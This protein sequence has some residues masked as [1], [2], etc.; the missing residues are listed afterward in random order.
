MRKEN[1]V[2]F[3]AVSVALAMAAGAFMVGCSSDSSST[4]TAVDS[5]TPAVDSGTTTDSGTTPATD[6][7]TTPAT[8][9][10]TTADAG[11]D[12]GPVDAGPPGP[13]GIVIDVVHASPDTPAVGLCLG[14]VVGGNPAFPAPFD[15]VQGPLP[16]NAA[17]QIVVPSALQGA[18]GGVE[19]RVYAVP[20]YTI[21]DGGASTCASVTGAGGSAVLLKSFP[22]GTFQAGHGYIV[23][24]TGCSNAGT[25]TV[26]KCG[27]DPT[28]PANPRALG[29]WFKEFDRTF[30]PAGNVGAQFVHL[31]PQAE[32]Q[33]LPV[34]GAGPDGGTAYLPIFA[35]GVK[36]A[37][38][39]ANPADAGT[40]YTWAA[41]ASGADP[42]K[43]FANPTAIVSA[44]IPVDPNTL[45]LGLFT[46]AS[47]AASPSGLTSIASIP[48]QFVAAATVGPT[49]P[50]VPTYFHKGLT[51]TFF[52]VGDLA[53]SSNPQAPNAGPD[54]FRVLALPNNPPPPASD[55]GTP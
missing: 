14:A 19:V 26:A 47:T 42:V 50:A 44:P 2:R 20:G 23:A 35:N 29:A 54:F 38:G 6:S 55:A 37:V 41:W 3:S 48:F 10:G 51:Y 9:S 4:A 22:A 8:D 18:I 27:A 45:G 28:T 30:Q 39:L 43:A 1:L 13:Q 25:A 49:N 11:R 36:V 52:A 5:G 16:R 31:S 32:S 15:K 46:A 34:P 7:G 17:T 24:A 21:P 33:A 53:Q 12:A 40:A